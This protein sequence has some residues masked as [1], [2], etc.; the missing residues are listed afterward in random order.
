MQRTVRVAPN[1]KLAQIVL[2]TS[3]DEISRAK[4]L[5]Q[6]S[7]VGR[8][9]RLVVAST[10]EGEEEL[11]VEALITPGIFSS[12]IVPRHPDR[13]EALARDIRKKFG[14]KVT[15]VP[16][17]HIVDGVPLE[18]DSATDNFEKKDQSISNKESLSLS[19]TIVKGFGALTALYKCADVAL[20]GG[21]LLNENAPGQHNVVEPLQ[22]GCITLH[23]AQANGDDSFQSLKQ[24][25]LDNHLSEKELRTMLRSLAI[26]LL[27]YRV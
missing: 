25:F 20:V 8:N 16:V 23:G 3:K 4:L 1:M 6:G 21:A 17:S 11:V 13:V 10:H 5:F 26:K 14:I 7:G 19:V 27:Y 15:I 22:H 9:L 24:S 2:P 18:G 12:V